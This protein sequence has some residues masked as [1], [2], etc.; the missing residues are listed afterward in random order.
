MGVTP[1]RGVPLSN[2]RS[3]RFLASCE[4]RRGRR[5]GERGVDADRASNW[6]IHGRIWPG[7]PDVATAVAGGTCTIPE[8]ATG[9][10]PVTAGMWLDGVGGDAAFLRRDLRAVTSNRARTASGGSLSIPGSS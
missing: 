2:T 4:E 10:H 1:W 3:T 5:T 8:R 9:Q 6:P 7:D